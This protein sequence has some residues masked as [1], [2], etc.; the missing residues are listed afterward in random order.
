MKT[1][2]ALV[3]TCERKA[4]A[5]LPDAG[6]LCEALRSL[7]A[8]E[9]GRGFDVF[10]PHPEHERLAL[11]GDGE[12]PFVIVEC[13][14]EDPQAL[15][16]WLDDSALQDALLQACAPAADAA[17]EAPQWRAGIFRVEREPVPS[18]RDDGAAPLSL[19]VH[20]YGP[21][22]DPAR[23]AAHYVANHPPIL[24]RLPA[25]REVLCYVP[26]GAVPRMLPVDATVIRNEVRFDSM[27]ALLASLRS[28]VLADLRA[29]TKTFPRFGRST[30]YPMLRRRLVPGG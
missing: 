28:P 29:D 19:V 27:D 6:R 7:P 20:Y 16:Q 17:A 25:V 2:H 15:R 10:V 26:T 4:R 23:F 22:D 5:P 21:V 8:L 9:G 12:P 13:R 18:P 1:E 14:G 11:F 3:F 24:A 30:H